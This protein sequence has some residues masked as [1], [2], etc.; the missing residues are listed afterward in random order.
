MSAD[1]KGPEP[2]EMCGACGVNQAREPHVCPY[3][4]DIN[5]DDETLCDCCDDCTAECA[6]DV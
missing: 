2:V 5:D 6:Y 3:Q 4:S 1:E